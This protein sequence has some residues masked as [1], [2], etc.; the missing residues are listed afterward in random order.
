MEYWNDN[1]H[2]TDQIDASN[3]FVRVNC[4]SGT[5]SQQ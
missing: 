2:F 5:N 4:Y 3:E 1:K